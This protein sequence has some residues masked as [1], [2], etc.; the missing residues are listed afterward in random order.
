[1]LLFLA[2]IDKVQKASL[3]YDEEFAYWDVRSA[4]RSRTSKFFIWCWQ[5]CNK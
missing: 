3:S 4:G 2:S 1:L 5:I